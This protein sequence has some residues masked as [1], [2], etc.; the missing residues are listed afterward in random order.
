MR[1]Q[2]PVVMMVPWQALIGILMGFTYIYTTPSSMTNHLNYWRG[3]RCAFSP[4]GDPDMGVS[5]H[6]QKT[7]PLLPQMNNNLQFTSHTSGLSNHSLISRK[8]GE[9]PWDIGRRQIQKMW[10]K[11]NHCSVDCCRIPPWNVLHSQLH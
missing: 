8:H 6:E 1:S 9:I 2:L 7:E 11:Q 10:L 5:L 3:W 4:A